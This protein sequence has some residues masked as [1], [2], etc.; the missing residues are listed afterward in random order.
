MVEVEAAD[1]ATPCEAEEAMRRWS[2][3]LGVEEDLSAPD[4]RLSRALGAVYGRYDPAEAAGGGQARRSRGSLGRSAPK[5]IAGWLGD[6]RDFFPRDVVQVVQRD[7]LDRLGLTRL[8]LEP[9]VLESV[10]RDVNLV[11][12]LMALRSVMPNKAKAAARAVVAEVVEALLERLERRTAQAV[13][14]ALDRTR[15]TARPRPADID[16]PRTIL[17]NLRHYQPEH[18]TVVPERLVGFG[19]RRRRLADL[20]QL[21]L[22]LDQSGS[23]AT[24]VVYGSIFAAVLASLPALDTRLVCFDTSVVDLTEQLADP[25]DVLFGIQLG[26]GTDINQAVAYCGGLFLQP[27]KSHLVLLTDLF[28]GGDQ[29]QLL[30]RLAS[31][32]RAGL[33]VIVLLALSDQGRPAYS[34]EAAQAVAALGVPVF[35]CTPDHVPDLMAAAQRRDAIAAWAAAQDIRLV[36]PAA[37]RGDCPTR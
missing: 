1:L 8:L 23:M 12:D 32:T 9:E 10:E 2:L 13:R 5:A 33:N 6:L 30:R 19:R 7:A 22:C 14:G 35:A 18:R 16:W 29:E 24:S 26:G 36:R 34:V 3:A 31:L 21:V 27:M 11:A 28:E 25:V 17:A 4:R 37:E 15:R 20:D